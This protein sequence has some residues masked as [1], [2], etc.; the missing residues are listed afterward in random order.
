MAHQ[1]F[2]PEE[3]LAEEWRPVTRFEAGAYEVSNIGRVRSWRQDHVTGKILRACPDSDGYLVLTLRPPKQTFKVHVLVAEAF[4]GPRPEGH[5]VNHIHPPKTNNAV[6][7]LEWLTQL[8]NAQ[9]A[10]R[11]GLRQHGSG[12]YNA[13]LT[14]EQV[15]DIRARLAAGHLQKD[16]AASFGVCDNLISMIARGRCWRH[17]GTPPPIE[18]VNRDK[19]TAAQVAEV[20]ARLAAGAFQTVIAKEC[21]LA[22][23]VVGRIARGVHPLS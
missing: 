9:H 11:T 18:R 4:I 23:T 22:R 6:S 20:K 17:V 15:L 3:L 14:E 10:T 5:E 19:T 16:I 13:I 21:N 1:E 12:H 2:T 7:N 8:Q